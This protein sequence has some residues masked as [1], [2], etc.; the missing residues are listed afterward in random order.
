MSTAAVVLRDVQLSRGCIS[1]GDAALSLSAWRFISNSLL[2][3]SLR[4]QANTAAEPAAA[5][6]KPTAAA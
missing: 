3:L 1:Q 4:R 5:V 6:F 2:D